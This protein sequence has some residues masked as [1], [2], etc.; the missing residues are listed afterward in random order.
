MLGSGFSPFD[1]EQLTAHLNSDPELRANM[2]E[3]D[4]IRGP[5]NGRYWLSPKGRLEFAKRGYARSEALRKGLV[6]D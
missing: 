1:D 4:L 6:D 5:L 2:L 3:H